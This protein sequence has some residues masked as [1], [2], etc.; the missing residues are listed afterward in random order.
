MILML[1]LDSNLLVF[2]AG[3]HARKVAKALA[4]RG[5]HVQAFISTQPSAKSLDDVPVHSWQ[6]LLDS[7]ISPSTQILCAIFNPVDS[8]KELSGIACR[9]GFKELIMPWDYYPYLSEQLGWCYWLSPTPPISF[10]VIE[11]SKP[12]MDVLSF[13]EDE[14][15]RVT[16]RRLHAFRNGDDLDY[17]AMNSHDRHYFNNLTLESKLFN[18]SVTYLDV[19]AYNGDTLK[20]LVSLVTVGR[21]LLFEPD[22]DNYRELHLTLNEL[23]ELYPDMSIEAFP[24]ALGN[25]DRFLSFSGHGESATLREAV[26]AVDCRQIHVVRFDDLFPF[27]IVDFIKIDA[28]GSDL[29]VLKGMELL[30]RRSRPILA[31]SLYHLPNDIIELPLAVKQMVDGFAYKYYI[32]QHMNN[33]FESVLYAVPC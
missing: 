23:H 19:G 25:K 12:Y 18:R 3:S 27:D 8:Y 9:Y 2:G 26:D 28:E 21:A 6:S 29:E 5:H 13:L 16:F 14:E 11:S 10:E 20:L 7:R 22:S 31:V 24:L 15:S 32:R 30:I 1:A 33:S 17:S 4:E